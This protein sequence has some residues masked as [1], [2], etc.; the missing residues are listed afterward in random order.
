MGNA[1]RNELIGP[2]LYEI[3]FS[4]YKNT[5]MKWISDGA[6]LQIR[7]E[8]YNILN[9]TNFDAPTDNFQIYDGSGNPVQSAG[10]IDQTTTSSRQIQLG[11]KLTF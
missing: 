5:P 6:N 2:N 8:I 3:D 1:G 7:A 11:V 9:H 10:L 4:G